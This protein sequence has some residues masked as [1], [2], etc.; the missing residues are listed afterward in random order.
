MTTY[1]S[2]STRRR[3]RGAV[4]ILA[5]IALAV[6]AALAGATL[7]AMMLEVR[8][9]RIGRQQA[10]AYWL[11]EAGIERAMANLRENPGYEGET[12]DVPAEE[13]TGVD[14]GRVRIWLE[15]DSDEA[16]S[17]QRIVAEAEYPRDSTTDS[18]QRRSAVWRP[19]PQKDD[20]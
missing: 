20:P 7:R 6:V 10:Q 11:A 3:A 17:A 13:I 12:W 19:L 18:R 16:A 9:V 2:K 1:R 14:A 5:L 4:A 15:P 8:A